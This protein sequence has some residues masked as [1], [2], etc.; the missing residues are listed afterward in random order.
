MTGLFRLD[1]GALGSS[2][3]PGRRPLPPAAAIFRPIPA[4][5]PPAAGRRPVYP[6][7]PDGS[8]AMPDDPDVSL[9]PA[10]ATD[11]LARLK[12]LV[13]DSV[14]SPNSR[15]AYDKALDDFLGWYRAA[16]NRAGPRSQSSGRQGR[17]LAR[18]GTGRTD[19]RRPRYGNIEGQTR[20]RDPGPPA[21]LRPAPQRSR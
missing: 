17:E 9:V 18:Q 6:A 7:L 21:G 16:G 14:T 5:C 3:P 4:S 13:L 10:V 20:P 19:D 1:L 15:R 11:D 2:R 12:A 8:S